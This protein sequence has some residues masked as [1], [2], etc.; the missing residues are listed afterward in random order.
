MNYLPKNKIKRTLLIFVICCPIFCFGQKA[1]YSP[2]QIR[3]DIQYLHKYLKE[4]HPNLYLY[5]TK[6]QVDSV[7]T[8]LVESAD[9]SMTALGIYNHITKL[10]G[11]VKDG[12][13]LFFP[14]DVM[15]EYH[16]SHSMFFPFKL[17]FQKDRLYVEL[18][19][20]S[21]NEIENGIEILSINGVSSAQII[22][23]CL[24]RMMRDGNDFNYPVWIL[25]NYFAEYY[26]YFY[27]HPNEFFIE[28]KAGDGLKKTIKV[29]GLPK[30]AIREIRSKKYPDRVR[31]RGINQKEGD[32]ILL[33]IDTL[34]NT[35]ILTIRDFDSDILQE[36][37]KQDF[38]KTIMA[39]FYQIRQSQVKNLIIDLRGNQGGNLENGIYL[40]SNILNDNFKVVEQFYVVKNPDAAT[41]TERNKIKRAKGKATYTPDPQAFK[42]DIYLLV[43]GGSFS[44]S[45]IVSATFRHYK[46]G[47]II[48][49]ETGGN[50]NVICGWEDIITLPHSRI[51]VHIPTRQL[52]IREKD[53]NDGHGLIP[54]FIVMP[55]I[56]E[57]IKGRDEVMDFTLKLIQ[58]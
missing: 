16:N 49:E 38:K 30:S 20:S 40:L 51:S 6:I 52:V 23:F 19:Y 31:V 33:N 12:H 50:K 13:T 4:K 53:K 35:A 54:D 32:G 3:E 56:N 11:I 37:H 39:M 25:N 55:T 18:N 24:E 43:D 15:L 2:V 21:N 44:N 36:I 22:N 1:S 5:A 42:G 17:F 45:G 34:K 14:S 58:D 48:G 8:E 29:D 47:K 28:V 9:S 46:R 7:F 10:L 26:S 27:G 41:E 57:L